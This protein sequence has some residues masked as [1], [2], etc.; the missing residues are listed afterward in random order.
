MHAGDIELVHMIGLEQDPTGRRADTPDTTG[1]NATTR[2]LST[3][4]LA[5]STSASERSDL[6]LPRPAGRL[7]SRSA[8]RTVVGHDRR[9][10]VFIDPIAVSSSRL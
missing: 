2:R 6:E 5:L 1:S 7:H 8:R 9:Q 10:T 3:A 4:L